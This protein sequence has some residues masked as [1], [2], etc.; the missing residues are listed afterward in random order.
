MCA[1]IS[2]YNALSEGLA[3]I[4][5]TGSLW[6]LQSRRGRQRRRCQERI[7]IN[8]EAIPFFFSACIELPVS[9]WLISFKLKRF[10]LTEH[11]VCDDAFAFRL[12]FCSVSV[13]WKFAQKFQRIC[14][15]LYSTS[16]GPPEGIKGIIDVI[17]ICSRKVTAAGTIQPA[18]KVMIQYLHV[19]RGRKLCSSFATQKRCQSAIRCITFFPFIFPSKRGCVHRKIF[20]ARTEFVSRKYGSKQSVNEDESNPAIKEN[21]VQKLRSFHLRYGKIYENLGKLI[22]N[23][24]LM[25]SGPSFLEIPPFSSASWG[26]PRGR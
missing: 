21:W 5:S 6:F 18:R 13:C 8:N 3:R 17:V 20:P 10:L 11:P 22:E 26:H 9:Y 4:R 25:L 2:G 15:F 19:W 16:H 23:K 7:M 14:T 24:S 1:P 12:V